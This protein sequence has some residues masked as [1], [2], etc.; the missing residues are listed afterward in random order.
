MNLIGDGGRCRPLFS[1]N[2]GP[3]ELFSA[4]RRKNKRLIL[5]QTEV[6]PDLCAEN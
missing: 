3:A 5:E 4:F 2:R 6:S 1:L